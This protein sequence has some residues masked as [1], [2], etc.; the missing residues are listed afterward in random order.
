M[1]DL[2]IEPVSAETVESG[3]SQPFLLMHSAG[4]VDLSAPSPNFIQIGELIENSS[5]EVTEFRIEGTTHHDFTALP[6]LTPLADEIGL[7]G[8]ID[9][10]TGLGLINYYSV[11]FFDQVLLGADEGLLDE[12]NSPFEEAQFGLRDK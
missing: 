4:W 8:P 5:G 12:A 10:D 9:G 3:L 7:K 11:S 2:W 1:M 6:L